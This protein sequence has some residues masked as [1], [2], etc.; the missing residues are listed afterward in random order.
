M[1]IEQQFGNDTLTILANFNV[2]FKEAHIDYNNSSY[3]INYRYPQ[4]TTYV[5]SNNV[6]QTSENNV[7]NAPYYECTIA[8][9]SENNE[10]YTNEN[11]DY[12]GALNNC[13]LNT[14]GTYEIPLTYNGGSSRTRSIASNLYQD[15]YLDIQK[16]ASV[17]VQ[18]SPSPEPEEP[19]TETKDYTNWFILLSAILM[20]IVMYRFIGSLFTRG[21]K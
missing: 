9:R 1:H 10:Y 14:N 6:T 12:T 21:E 18:P 7:F 4:T 3:A 16:W 5:F 2:K 20:L 13:V 8:L 19:S 17:E 15:N 11:F